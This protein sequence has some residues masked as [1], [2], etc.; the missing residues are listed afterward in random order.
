MD[1]IP[2]KV[3]SPIELAQGIEKKQKRITI[4]IKV[5]IIIAVIIIVGALAYRYKGLLI[6]AM[7]D[8]SFIS[9]F[10]VI[11]ELEKKS[12]KATLDALIIQKL[13]ETEAQK[14]GVTVSD[15]DVNAEIK[16]IEDQVKD[17]KS[18]V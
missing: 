4:S 3:K 17:R 5:A 15:N 10:S 1:T 16:K 6:A 8:G 2:E 13:I 18:V 14:K 7:V 11:E 9:R 12:G